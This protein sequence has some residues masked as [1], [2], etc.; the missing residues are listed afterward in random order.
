MNQI[1]AAVD[2]KAWVQ[3][4]ENM[5]PEQRRWAFISVK[6][7]EHHKT[8]ADM[9]RRHRVT[10]W[11]VSECAQGLNG[12]RLTPKMKRILESELKIDLEPFMSPLE[13]WNV[14]K[15]KNL[16]KGKTKE[17]PI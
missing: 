6:M 13:A 5:T 8:F 10:G 2:P 12:S 1:K 14:D 4:F 9:G 15:E 17:E 16:T 11:Y 7:A 3:A